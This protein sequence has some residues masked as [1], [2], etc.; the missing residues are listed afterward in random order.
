MSQ[1]GP[2]GD[3]VTTHLQRSI[4]HHLI[5]G[6]GTAKSIIYLA[7]HRRK[8][9][10]Q[11]TGKAYSV[12][13][14][15]CDISLTDP[16]H[17]PRLSKASALLIVFDRSIVVVVHVSCPLTTYDPRWSFSSSITIYPVRP[18]IPTIGD[19]LSHKL[20]QLR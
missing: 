4:R 1:V 14:M 13:M 19:Y 2:R 18:L 16:A 12:V 15:F 8:V 17:C 10:S 7:L 11:Y 5:E 3:P 9:Y 6:K 20:L